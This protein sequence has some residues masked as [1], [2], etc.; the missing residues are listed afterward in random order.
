MPLKFRKIGGACFANYCFPENDCHQREQHPWIRAQSPGRADGETDNLCTTC[1]QLNLDFLFRHALDELQVSDNGSTGFL[2][3]GIRLG[4]L[5]QIKQNRACPLCSLICLC[6][7]QNDEVLSNNPFTSDKVSSSSEDNA[8]LECY[9]DNYICTP[10]LTRVN[11]IKEINGKNPSHIELRIRT[12]EPYEASPGVLLRQTSGDV[13]IQRIQP[14]PAMT[15]LSS[16]DYSL[17]ASFSGLGNAI[18]RGSVNPNQLATWVKTCLERDKM[19]RNNALSVVQP[20][21]ASFNIRLVDVKRHCLVQPT[22]VPDFVALSY[23]WGKV[24]PLVLTQEKLATFQQEGWLSPAN[25]QIPGTIRDAITLCGLMGESFLWVDSLCIVQDSNDKFIQ[26]QHMDAIY[27]Q[28]KFTIIATAGSDANAGLPGVTD[29]SRKTYQHLTRIQGHSIANVLPHDSDVLRTAIWSYRGWTLQE[30]LLS[31]RK[32][33]FTDYQVYYKCSHGGC[34]ED[35]AIDVHHLE[36]HHRSHSDHIIGEA[37]TT[38][39]REYQTVVTQYTNRDLSY[40]ADAL[41]A[42]EGI[43]SYLCKSL[44]RESR[45]IAGTP[46]CI[47]DLALLWV[48]KSPLQRRMD[49]AQGTYPFPSWSWVGWLGAVDYQREESESVISRVKWLNGED[50]TKQLPQELTGAPPSSWDGWVDW[51]RHTKEF[52]ASIYYTHKADSSKRRYCHPVVQAADASG[53]P[54]DP[55]TGYL[56]FLADVVEMAVTDDLYSVEGDDIPLVYYLA[57]RDA[58]G[59]QAGLVYVDAETYGKL[60]L[61][62]QRSYT[63]I[64]LSQT[65]LRTD[66]TEA[67]WDEQA[68]SFG[69]VPGT[70]AVNPEVDTEGAEEYFDIKYYD[71]ALCFCI[72]N[73][74]MVE[75]HEDVSSRIGLGVVHIHAFDNANP[76]KRKV[77]FG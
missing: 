63:F 7:K 77:T 65:T 29:G 46:T 58:Q 32:F 2:V 37:E 42:F 20:A 12:Q 8:Q 73:V 43:G 9:L 38:N 14:S 36:E 71:P 75:V 6:K 33:F 30:D 39:L 17:S 67:A 45:M 31:P 28:A 10:D 62:N 53:S 66:F 23:V 15:Y 35:C 11:T 70:P 16:G 41:A 22:N 50:L 27:N 59:H 19:T 51:E 69:G 25:H 34:R 49:Q 4:Y 57:V 18:P 1:S 3:D 48:P 40:Q 68:R 74:V 76:Q 60:D 72:Y 64:K 61:L 47:L 54:F 26:I 21:T 13:R 24:T 55:A 56:H 52:L 44:F 5:E